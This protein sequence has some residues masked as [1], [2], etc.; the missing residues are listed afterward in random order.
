MK[1]ARLVAEFVDADR[2]DVQH[3]AGRLS[4]AC[5]GLNVQSRLRKVVDA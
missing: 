3:P 2:K 1:A 4:A 5:L